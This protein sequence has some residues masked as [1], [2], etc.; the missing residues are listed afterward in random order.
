MNG[1]TATKIKSDLLLHFVPCFR[2]CGVGVLSTGS[3]DKFKY[4]LY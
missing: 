4:I 1:D 2:N 3:L